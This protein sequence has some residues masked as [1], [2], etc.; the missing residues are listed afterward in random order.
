MIILLNNFHKLSQSLEEISVPNV[1]ELQAEQQE[2]WTAENDSKLLNAASDFSN[3]KRSSTSTFSESPMPSS[4][5]LWDSISSSDPTKQPQ[6]SIFDTSFNDF[7]ASFGERK[8]NGDDEDDCDLKN[9]TTLE[10]KML[11]KKT[12]N[13]I[14]SANSAFR[15]VRTESNRNIKKL[16]KSD[17]GSPQRVDSAGR[18]CVNVER[19]RTTGEEKIDYREE[20]KE[21]FKNGKKEFKKEKESFKEENKDGEKNIVKSEN[22]TGVLDELG[23]KDDEKEL[24]DR[25]G[26]VLSGKLQMND[27]TVDMKMSSCWSEASLI[28]FNQEDDGDGGEQGGGSSSGGGYDNGQRVNDDGRGSGGGGSDGE[29]DGGTRKRENS[30]NNAK[31]AAYLKSCSQE[32]GNEKKFGDNDDEAGHLGNDDDGDDGV[33]AEGAGGSKARSDEL[34]YG[35]DNDEVL[36][37]RVERDGGLKGNEEFQ[38]EKNNYVEGGDEEE[39]EK[40]KEEEEED[41]NNGDDRVIMSNIGETE[42]PK[43]DDGGDK[44]DGKSQ[45]DLGSKEEGEAE[46]GKV[47]NEEEEEKDKMKKKENYD[48]NVGIS[49]VENEECSVK[50][51]EKEENGVD[52]EKNNF[53]NDGDDDDDDNNNDDDDDDNNDDDNTTKRGVPCD[54]SSS[55]VEAV[56][57]SLAGLLGEASVSTLESCVTMPMTEN[58]FTPPPLHHTPQTTSTTTQEDFLKDK[59]L[60]KGEKLRTETLKDVPDDGLSWKPTQD[61]A[62]A[63]T[64]TSSSSSSYFSTTSTTTTIA[65]STTVPSTSSSTPA[66]SLLPVAAGVLSSSSSSLSSSSLATTHL[67][68]TNKTLSDDDSTP[69]LQSLSN[70]MG[71]SK[72][73]FS[74]IHPPASIVHSLKPS[75]SS[76][77]PIH[78][79]TPFHHH[80]ISPLQ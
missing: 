61:A 12:R 11:S 71:E 31:I 36:E 43:R 52:E 58:Y 79:T 21:S 17:Q 29:A 7:S 74:L 15:K 33:G 69:T 50:N 41:Q 75:H 20:K 40:K 70:S 47:E 48:G 30:E 35:D 53:E 18:S 27:V 66:S 19:L 54:A 39:E 65:S 28:S 46:K 4:K 55:V 2:N 64:T 37:G 57:S 10:K 1:E 26:G 56:G 73:F 80:N 42:M 59:V 34:K 13:K 72:G 24:H 23:G 60:D 76:F 62:S 49:N 3:I 6:T 51:E 45:L 16:E 63:T 8:D 67:T 14:G 78:H 68:D 25:E 22:I 32:G 77:Q 9:L 38:D 44:K 5:S